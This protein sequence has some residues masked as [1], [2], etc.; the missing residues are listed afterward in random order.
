MVFPSKGGIALFLMKGIADIQDIT[1]V[2][3]FLYRT[4][5]GRPTVRP[6]TYLGAVVVSVFCVEHGREHDS[7]LSKIR[8]HEPFFYLS[9]YEAS[10]NHPTI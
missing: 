9:M 7:Y 2:S 10:L 3:L 6:T 5:G 4:W 8:T 1:V